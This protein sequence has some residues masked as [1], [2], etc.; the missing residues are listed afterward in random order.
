MRD[1]TMIFSKF[2]ELSTFESVLLDF[3][4]RIR[5]RDEAELLRGA[6]SPLRPIGF[7]VYASDASFGLI[8]AHEEVHA[9]A[10]ALDRLHPSLPG[11]AQVIS[12]RSSSRVPAW[13]QVSNALPKSSATIH[14]DDPDGRSSRLCSP[15]LNIRAA[16]AH[17]NFDVGHTGNAS[18]QFSDLICTLRS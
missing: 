1:Q 4:F 3:Y 13:E 7:S 6:Q 14:D 8:L 17:V 10:R 15:C 2:A 18:S 5:I 16:K 9:L 12:V 11:A